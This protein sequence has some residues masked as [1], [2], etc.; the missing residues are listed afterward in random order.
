[1]AAMRAKAV[2][3]NIIVA[4]MLIVVMLDSCV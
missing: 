1:M 3:R 2:A 4:G